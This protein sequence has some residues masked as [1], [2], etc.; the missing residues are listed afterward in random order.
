LHQDYFGEPHGTGTSA[1]PYVSCDFG[2]F[3][4]AGFPKPHAYWYTANWL[5]RFNASYLPNGR[6]PLPEKTV[7]RILST[8]YSVQYH[9][10]NTINVMT[11][12]PAGELFVDGKSVGTASA[13]TLDD[14][15]FL[16]M[17]FDLDQ[18][19]KAIQDSC[20]GKSSFNISAN[21]VQC[22]GLVS[23]AP[24]TT[25]ETCAEACCAMLGCNTWQILAEVGKNATCWIG[26]AQE[27]V[28]KCAKPKKEKRPW[29]G[30]QRVVPPPTPVK[31]IN[32]ATFLAL[33][34]TGKT[35][36]THTIMAPSSNTSA[37]KGSDEMRILLTLDVPSAT[38]G[39]GNSLVLD[40]RDV[41]MVRASLVGKDD[42]DSALFAV[43]NNRLTWR[44]VSGPG[45]VAGT[46]NGD[47]ASHEWMKSHSIDAYGGLARGMFR[48]SVDC[49]SM[50]HEVTP[51]I[52]LDAARSPTKIGSSA[53]ECKSLAVPIVVEARFADGSGTP[54]TISIPTSVDLEKDG[55][56]AV[57][58][59]G[60]T[61]DMTYLETFVG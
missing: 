34:V 56:M 6:P 30:G 51:S 59:A 19:V 9:T 44:V 31:A 36:A 43:A 5:Q 27:P 2:Q 15:T 58:K 35:L 14:G 42:G 47:P 29:I 28:G 45:V 23:G 40:G 16:E 10:S 38:T 33:S 46:A 49:T 55:V 60:V 3:D 17:V 4:I 50:N 26:F 20:T 37:P 11:S 8:P 53:S 18:H 13:T 22:H 1:W 52:D 57:A 54:M 12:A 39:T 48:V 61:S 25:A 41:A 7:A 32:N 21:G 24:A